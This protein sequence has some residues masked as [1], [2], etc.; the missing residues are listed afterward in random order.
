MRTKEE[1]KEKRYELEKKI[2]PTKINSNQWFYL[3][4]QFELLKWLENKEEE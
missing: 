2:P 3:K 1:I 4:G